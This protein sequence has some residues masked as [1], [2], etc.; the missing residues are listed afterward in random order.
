MSAFMLKMQPRSTQT[1]RGSKKDPDLDALWKKHSFVWQ[2]R[3][4]WLVAVEEGGKVKSLGCS[5]CCQAPECQRGQNVF[6]EGTLRTFQTSAFQKHAASIAHLARVDS[7]KSCEVP[8]VAPSVQ[9]FAQ[10]L[11]AVWQGTAELKETGPFKCRTMM[12]CAAEAWL[13]TCCGL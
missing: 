1:G 3:F 7:L 13:K 2:S 12:W 9:Q 6:A 5:I 8:V 4:P 11:E 10:L